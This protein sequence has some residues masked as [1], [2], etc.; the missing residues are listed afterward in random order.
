MRKSAFTPA[1]LKALVND[2]VFW[3]KHT[4]GTRVRKNLVC[5]ALIN[6]KSQYL[7]GYVNDAKKGI[8]TPLTNKWWQPSV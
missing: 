4:N 8:M 3:S 5:K 2:V 1:T 7:Q 6:G